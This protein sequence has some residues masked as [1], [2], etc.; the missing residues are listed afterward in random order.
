M[1]LRQLSCT[2]PVSSIVRLG[3]DF[4]LAGTAHYIVAFRIP[5]GTR[6]AHQRWS[7][8]HRERIHKIVVTVSP[9]TWQCI[10][11]GGKEV[12]LVQINST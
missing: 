8:L 10:V 1:T 5:T 7:V 12:S 2:A 11:L 3:D 9:T 4:V 6:S